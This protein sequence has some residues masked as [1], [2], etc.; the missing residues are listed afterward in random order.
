LSH[1]QGKVI[2]TTYKEVGEIELIKVQK[3]KAMGV[4][5]GSAAISEGWTA[6]D[7]GVDIDSIE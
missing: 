3:D 6:V 5:S 1:A 7:A 2:L 4:Y